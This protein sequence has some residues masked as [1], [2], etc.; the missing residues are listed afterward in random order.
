MNEEVLFEG[1]PKK[2]QTFSNALKRVTRWN[3]GRGEVYK[4][5]ASVVDELL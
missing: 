5:S 1:G 2:K 4:K 3:I